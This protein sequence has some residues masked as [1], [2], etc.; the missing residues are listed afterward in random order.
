[1]SE[2]ASANGEAGSSI[3]PSAFEQT[4]FNT[5]S[6]LPDGFNDSRITLTTW[7]NFHDIDHWMLP[8]AHRQHN[9]V[10]FGLKIAS[11]I[12]EFPQTQATFTRKEV[13]LSKQDVGVTRVLLHRHGATVSQKASVCTRYWNPDYLHYDA[14]FERISNPQEQV[15]FFEKYAA[16]G[17]SLE[18]MADHMA[19]P[20]ENQTNTGS[21]VDG[22]T[23]EKADL[24]AVLQQSEYVDP[25]AYLDEICARIA[26]GAYTTLAWTTTEMSTLAKA[27]NMPVTTLQSWIETYAIHPDWNPPERPGEKGWFAYNSEKTE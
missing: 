15:K 20:E 1:M 22:E 27:I 17:K 6:A 13:G 2:A 8:L 18:W 21:N 7:A 14:C 11:N 9:P 5:L 3:R 10:E 26:R 4:P 24:I 19:Y 23:F 25:E 12:E 16:V